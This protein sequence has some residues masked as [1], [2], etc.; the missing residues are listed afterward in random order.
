MTG[1]TYKFNAATL[2]NLAYTYDSLGRR[3]QVGGSFA[4]SSKAKPGHEG[5]MMAD[6]SGHVA[7]HEIDDIVK[8][9]KCHCHK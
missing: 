8:E 1:I 6:Y 9:M 2:G 7:Q 3:T 5:H 4:Q